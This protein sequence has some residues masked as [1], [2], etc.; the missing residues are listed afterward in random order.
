MN[1]KYS[2]EIITLSHVHVMI[3]KHAPHYWEFVRVMHRL[4]DYHDIVSSYQQLFGRPICNAVVQPGTVITQADTIQYLIHH[5]SEWS[6]IWIRVW[7]HKRHP[8]ARPNGRALGCL[9][10]EKTDRVKTEPR[11]I[12][13]GVTSAVNSIM[14]RSSTASDHTGCLSRRW[15]HHESIAIS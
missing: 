14:P 12:L 15:G 1:S 13:D 5:C 11:C 3:W 7:A 10:W 2:V 6:R 8:I 4:L 9:L